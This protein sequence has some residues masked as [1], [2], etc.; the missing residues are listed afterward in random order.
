MRTPRLR[1]AGAYELPKLAQAIE[2]E[3][4]SSLCS[5][6]AVRLL[7]QICDLN[8]HDLTKACEETIAADFE[9]LGQSVFVSVCS[10]DSWW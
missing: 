5:A 8:L 6:T 3:F 2:A 7:P 1:L 4:H 9:K 10:W